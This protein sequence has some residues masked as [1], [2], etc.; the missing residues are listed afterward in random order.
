MGHDESHLIHDKQ[1]SVLGLHVLGWCVRCCLT[2]H[3]HLGGE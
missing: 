2:I 3:V 1:D